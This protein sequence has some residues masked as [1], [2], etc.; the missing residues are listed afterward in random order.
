MWQ[1]FQEEKMKYNPAMEHWKFVQ[2][3]LANTG[4]ECDRCKNK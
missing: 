2:R 3:T 4:C 1:G